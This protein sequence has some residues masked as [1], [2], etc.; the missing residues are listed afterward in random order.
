[1]LHMLYNRLG[2]TASDE[3]YLAWMASLLTAAPGEAVDYF[4]DGPAAP[5]RAYHELSKFR[6]AT[7]DLQQPRPGDSIVRTLDFTSDGP[8]PLPQADPGLAAAPL[9]SVIAARRSART[10]LAGSIGLEPLA[11]LLGLGTGVVDTEPY[12]TDEPP[13]RRQV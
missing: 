6:P 7:M 1:H 13:H 8:L 3:V 2:L 5:D 4:A 11:T 10:G 9:S 12:E